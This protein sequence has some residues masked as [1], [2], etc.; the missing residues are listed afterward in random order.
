VDL[1]L[2]GEGLVSLRIEDDGIGLPPSRRRG[3]LGLQLI[4]M[5][6]QQVRGSV[7]LGNRADGAGTV[8]GVTF[9]DPNTAPGQPQT[10]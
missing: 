1:S 7:V 3:A 4:E 10:G 9:P 2:A 5:L 6:A 8:V